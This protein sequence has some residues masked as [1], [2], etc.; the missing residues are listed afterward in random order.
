MSTAGKVLVVLFLLASL[1]WMLL[2]AGV[3]QINRNYSQALL[4]LTEKVGKLQDDVKKTQ[5]DM[6]R[7]KD[8]TSVLQETMD[9]QL[10]VLNARQ[11]D[12]QRLASITSEKL[13]SSQYELATVQ[14]P[15]HNAEEDRAV[16]V[17]ELDADKKAL[18][19]AN[20]E[21]K[22]L[23]ATDENLRTRLAN[24]RDEFKKTLKH[25]VD[26]LHQTGK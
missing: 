23:K 3:D 18:N 10:A 20:A 26:V 17:A 5:E 1:V 8:Q 24:L 4:A 2:T 15:L 21:V 7:V 11:N 22:S 9:R 14:V 6:V 12:V 25:N 19:V 16:R 13:S